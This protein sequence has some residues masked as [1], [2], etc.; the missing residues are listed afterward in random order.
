LVAVSGVKVGVGS[1][2]VELF[3]EV[4]LIDNFTLVGRRDILLTTDTTVREQVANFVL[5]AREVAVIVAVPF[6]TAVTTPAML[7]VATVGFEVV[8]STV[9]TNTVAGAI[10]AII[11]FAVLTSIIQVDGLIL[12]PVTGAGTVTV[13]E[14]VLFVPSVDVGTDLAVIIAVPADTPVTTPFSTVAILEF[15]VLH[16]IHVGRSGGPIGNI[17]GI[18]RVSVR[19]IPTVAVLGLNLIL[20]TY[21]YILPSYIPS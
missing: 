8:Q 3:G 14:P 5:S 4:L 18:G 13:T 21:L 17:V 10:V 15:D 20:V 6:A 11:D 2:Y 19:A 7:T 1:V 16:V 12:T 9:F